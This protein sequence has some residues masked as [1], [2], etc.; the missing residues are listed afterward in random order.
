MMG[1]VMERRKIEF[2]KE[3]VRVQISKSKSHDEQVS[4]TRTFRLSVPFLFLLHLS[5][6]VPCVFHSRRMMVFFCRWYQEIIL[7]PVRYCSDKF[8]VAWDRYMYIFTRSS[9][10]GVVPGQHK[11]LWYTLNMPTPVE[12]HRTRRPLPDVDQSSDMNGLV[13]L[14]NNANSEMEDRAQ[15]RSN[16]R[17]EIRQD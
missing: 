17:A 16:S 13:G 6:R 1:V 9:L 10:R 11:Q 4:I 12:I 2:R 7:V 3:R 15:K 5:K 14:V 8:W